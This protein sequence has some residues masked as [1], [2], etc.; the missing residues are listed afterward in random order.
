MSSPSIRGHLAL[1]LTFLATA[2]HDCEKRVRVYAIRLG[3]WHA[4]RRAD[5]A[6]RSSLAAMSDRELQDVGLTQGDVLDVSDHS[7]AFA[8]HEDTMR[9]QP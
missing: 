1:K 9:R 6:A 5:T 7:R 8:W 4:R 2:L 3:A